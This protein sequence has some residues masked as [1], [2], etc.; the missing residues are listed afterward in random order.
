ML[1][2]GPLPEAREGFEADTDAP[3]LAWQ[4]DFATAI[5][6]SCRVARRTI[7]K[8]L[9]ST[10]VEL[11]LAEVGLQRGEGDAERAPVIGRGIDAGRHE[12]R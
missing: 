9:D 2:A 4:H 12:T 5:G 10:V 11:N 3:S 7:V 8:A 6:P 1:S